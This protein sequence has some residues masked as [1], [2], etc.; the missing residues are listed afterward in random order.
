MLYVKG[1]TKAGEVNENLNIELKEF[2]E[3]LNPGWKI[4][5]V[6]TKS[7]EKGAWGYICFENSEQCR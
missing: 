6:F 2:F 5:G 3:K 7:N 1:L 4:P